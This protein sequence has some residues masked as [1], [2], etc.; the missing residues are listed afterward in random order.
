MLSFYGEYLLIL[1]GSLIEW[2]LPMGMQIWLPMTFLSIRTNNRTSGPG[3]TICVAH[4]KNMRTVMGKAP[5]KQYISI[6]LG[7]SFRVVSDLQIYGLGTFQGIF[8][9]LYHLSATFWAYLFII[10]QI[11]IATSQQ[12]N[13]RENANRLSCEMLR[14]RSP[15][16]Y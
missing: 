3:T 4:K 12:L 15:K 7:T 2:I 9:F 1:S 16:P 14:T 5:S 8:L 13:Y 11:L 10:L 6:N